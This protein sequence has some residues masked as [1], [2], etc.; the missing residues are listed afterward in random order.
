M[1][2]LTLNLNAHVW[3]NFLSSC[4]QRWWSGIR[5]LNGCGWGKLSRDK[6][7]L[8]SHVAGWIQMTLLGVCTT[9]RQ[10]STL[11]G[12]SRRAYGA[13]QGLVQIW[14]GHGPAGG[15]KRAY[16]ATSC[17]NCAMRA[18][19]RAAHAANIC[20]RVLI[21]MSHGIS[22]NPPFFCNKLIDHATWVCSLYF[23]FKELLT[24]I[25]K[26]TMQH[27]WMIIGSHMKLCCRGTMLR[28]F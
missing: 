1:Y 27:V 6:M 16:V 5:W 18:S 10:P 12:G 22:I 11:P 2:S 17:D 23:R 21:L 24:G 3:N 20:W 26:T 19:N 28:H 13:W 7:S 25:L 4:V 8:S 15:N 14:A 9:P